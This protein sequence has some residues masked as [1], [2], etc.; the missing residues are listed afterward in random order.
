MAEE[1]Q[2]EQ[3]RAERLKLVEQDRVYNEYVKQQQE[4]KTLFQNR[5]MKNRVDLIRELGIRRQLASA[6]P[7]SQSGQKDTVAFESRSELALDA[8]YSTKYLT[9][10]ELD[11]EA[12][13]QAHRRG[14]S[15]PGSKDY[16]PEVRQL[17]SAGSLL[18]EL[19][20][21]E[22][23]LGG[24][25]LAKQQ[26]GPR[27]EESASLQSVGIKGSLAKMLVPEARDEL[28]ERRQAR[29]ENRSRKMRG[30][31]LRQFDRVY[32]GTKR[33]SGHAQGKSLADLRK[34][35][36]GRLGELERLCCPGVKFQEK[37][38]PG[39]RSVKAYEWDMMQAP[40]RSQTFGGLSEDE[41][42]FRAFMKEVMG[43]D[44]VQEQL[45]EDLESDSKIPSPHDPRFNAQQRILKRRAKYMLKIGKKPMGLY[46]K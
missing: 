36:E 35:N 12:T 15:R 23:Q 28:A 2:K 33:M 24:G 42:V 26:K 41:Y 46:S 30:E 43:R 18:D 8:G 34:E 32:G 16:V 1:R 20:G 13:W 19:R 4:F 10:K 38:G 39:W 14:L 37:K 44:I 45:R 5:I 40:H 7:K 27:R 3:A 22:R 6:K 29:I 21:L 31:M 17:A 9:A 11:K 25:R